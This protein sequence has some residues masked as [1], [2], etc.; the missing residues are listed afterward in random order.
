MCAA[1]WLVRDDDFFPVI[2]I[3]YRSH[4][5]LYDVVRKIRLSRHTARNFFPLAMTVLVRLVTRGPTIHSPQRRDCSPKFQMSYTLRFS[6]TFFTSRNPRH[7]LALRPHDFLNSG[8]DFRQGF[9][10][11]MLG[12]SHE[13]GSIRPAAIHTRSSG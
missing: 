1:S 12:S 13:S 4:K 8:N 5:N 2:I 7:E 3:I 11:G 9:E 10:Q 6:K